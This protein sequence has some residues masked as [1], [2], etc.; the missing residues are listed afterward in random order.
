MGLGGVPCPKSRPKTLDKRAIA[1]TK[2][3][4]WR[5]LTQRVRER[6]SQTCRI[7]KRAPGA[8]VHHVE[9][10]SRGGKDEMSNCLL[11]CR[12]CHTDLH[13][14][15]VKLAGNAQTRGGLRIARWS[16]DAKDYVWKVQK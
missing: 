15:V 2:A 4:Q 5:E 9:F 11:V 14:H 6:D 12:G 3:K 10:R 16:D 1:A 8:E 13:A 7:C